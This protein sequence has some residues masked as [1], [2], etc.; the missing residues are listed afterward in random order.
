MKKVRNHVHK[1]YI[2]SD[3]IEY[4]GKA[5]KKRKHLEDRIADYKLIVSRVK[6]NARGFKCPGSMSN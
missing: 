1:Q 2:G 3:G 4:R 6:E 5:V